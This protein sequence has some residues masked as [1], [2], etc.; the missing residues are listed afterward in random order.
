MNALCTEFERRFGGFDSCHAHFTL[1]TYPFTATVTA[2][3]NIHKGLSG[4][5]NDSVAQ[6]KHRELKVPKY[7]Q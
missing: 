7:F 2:E 6:A 1:F 3:H 5:Q 4:P